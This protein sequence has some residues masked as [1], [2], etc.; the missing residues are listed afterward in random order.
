MCVYVCVHVHMCVY[1]LSLYFF[2][3]FDSHLYPF[4]WISSS[5]ELP[6][7]GS[8]LA[9]DFL[10]W[11][12][13]SPALMMKYQWDHTPEL[14]MRSSWGYTSLIDTFA[15]LLPLLYPVVIIILHIYSKRTSW[16]NPLYNN[17]FLMVCLW[18]T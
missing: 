15:Q 2:I 18:R 14:P 3:F 11:S 12:Y 8:F 1:S 17:L 5:L 9:N 4:L 13:S 7:L 10:R 16:I 6:S